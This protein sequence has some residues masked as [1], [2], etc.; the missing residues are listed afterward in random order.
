MKKWFSLVAVVC[1]IS[2]T[3]SAQYTNPKTALSKNKFFNHLDASIT[4]GSTGVG[5]DLA[6]PIGNYL[7]VRTGFEYMPTFDYNTSFEIQIGDTKESKYD[8][9]GK[10]VE[11]RFDRMA[12][13]LYEATGLVADDQIEMIGQPTF[14][15]F[16][17]L[18]DIFPFKHNKHWHL[19]T[20]FHWG[21]S[22]IGKAFNTTEDMSSLV[23]VSLYNH[24]YEVAYDDL[25]SD[26]GRA[27]YDYYYMDPDTENRL[28][29]YG[30]MAI[31]VGDYAEDIA[32]KD[33][34]IVHQKG[35]PYMMEPNGENMVKVDAKVNSF[36][37]YVGFGYGG[38][39]IK[40][41]DRYQVS[42][43]CGV[44][45]WGGAP[46]VVTHDGTDLTKDVEN[47]G[48]KVGDYVDLAKKATAFP[49]LNFRI[50]RRLF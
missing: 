27:V 12:N 37:P 34:N 44:M 3:V 39:L 11:T 18:I 49:V 8:A 47:I 25:H 7:M 46:K 2:T 14:H 43:D 10:R 32:D 5:I 36:K 22:R 13:A 26:A 31:H 42:F 48:G 23:M 4:L 24:L 19:T 30:R 6:A 15:N 21:P 29:R 20:G 45:F 9:N 38:R 50:S 28:M 33:G 17:F 1:M 16:K 40:G 35:E 41:D